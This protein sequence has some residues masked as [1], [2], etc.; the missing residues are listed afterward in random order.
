M[1]TKNSDCPKCGAYRMSQSLMGNNDMGRAVFFCTECK[2][3]WV[4]FAKVPEGRTIIRESSGIILWRNEVIKMFKKAKTLKQKQ[5][6]LKYI[7]RYPSKKHLSDSLLT[8][9]R[10]SC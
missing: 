2:H 4:M 8:T 9:L 6:L 10:S 5:K 7:T 1:A 3:E